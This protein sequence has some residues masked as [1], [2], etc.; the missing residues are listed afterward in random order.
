MWKYVGSSV[1]GT[2]H[3]VQG[4]PCQDAHCIGCSQNRSGLYFWAI[5]TDGAGSARYAEQ[6]ATL[7]CQDISTRIERWVSHFNAGN[8]PD[9]QIVIKWIERVRKQLLRR[10]H[11]VGGSIRDFACTLVGIIVGNNGAI[12]FQIGDGSIVLGDGGGT[13]EIAFWPD[14]GEYVNTTYFV[15]DADFHSTLSFK[16]V[17]QAPVEIALFSDGLQRLSLHTATK[18]VHAPFFA[19]MFYRLAH[20]TPG[21]SHFLEPELARFL[22]SAEVNK[23]TDDDK[24]LVLATQM[25]VSAPD[26]AG[27]TENNGN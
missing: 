21:F 4:T 6:G 14:N 23:R 9:K 10:A 15:T 2:S 1:I 18:S 3:T 27:H 16:T 5:V 26:A 12:C 17:T 22:G 20:E 25:S 8:L 19:P 7:V 13:Y 11:N 24:T